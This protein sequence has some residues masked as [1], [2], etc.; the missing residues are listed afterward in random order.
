MQKVPKVCLTTALALVD[1]EHNRFF[2][3]FK[4]MFGKFEI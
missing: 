3:D 1:G 4:G 2:L